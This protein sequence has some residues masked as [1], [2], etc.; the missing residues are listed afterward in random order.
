MVGYLNDSWT[1]PI[2]KFLLPADVTNN[3]KMNINFSYTEETYLPS[4]KA[5]C[6]TIII[7]KDFKNSTQQFTGN[8]F[9]H[10][11]IMVCLWTS[12]TFTMGL[13]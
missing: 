9:P 4:G 3:Y 6:I 5:A 11:K 10:M 12:P 2:G 8:Q 13:P 7:R 1:T